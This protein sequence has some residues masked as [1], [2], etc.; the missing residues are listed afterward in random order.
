MLAG[1]IV[2][3]IIWQSR[4]GQEHLVDWENLDALHL[5]CDPAH[6]NGDDAKRT[7]DRTR[8]TAAIFDN[9]IHKVCSLFCTHGAAVVNS[10]SIL[11][12]ADT[13]VLLPTK[14]PC[15]A[16]T[17]HRQRHGESPIWATL[18]AALIL[19]SKGWNP[20]SEATPKLTSKLLSHPNRGTDT[21]NDKTLGSG[22][23][24]DGNHG[25]ANENEGDAHDENNDEEDGVGVFLSHIFLRPLRHNP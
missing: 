8:S 25:E 10:R 2:I 15:G 16:Q 23:I 21:D 11:G 14:S 5:P 24:A 19:G 4:V 7:K 1:Q 9:L 12:E 20:N 13:H 22:P 3:V 6:V 18:E 17:E